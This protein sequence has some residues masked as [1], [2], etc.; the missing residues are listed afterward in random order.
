MDTIPRPSSDTTI[1][2]Q[3]ASCILHLKSAFDWQRTG[4][5]KLYPPQL[6]GTLYM[7]G[8][9]PPLSVNGI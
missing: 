1:F 6:K 7:N 2:A 9:T 4:L 5:D 3:R 8:A